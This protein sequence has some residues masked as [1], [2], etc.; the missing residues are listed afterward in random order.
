M[1][2]DRIR[3]SFGLSWVRGGPVADDSAECKGC[4]TW[5]GPVPSARSGESLKN[6]QQ[7]KTECRSTT[8]LSPLQEITSDVAATRT[9]VPVNSSDR[10]QAWA[11]KGSTAAACSVRSADCKPPYVS[12]YARFSKANEMPPKQEWMGGA[13]ERSFDEASARLDDKDRAQ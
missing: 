4:G 9:S 5:G 3:T 2:T 10:R 6:G 1:T 7:T 8:P 11:G 12:T 13:S